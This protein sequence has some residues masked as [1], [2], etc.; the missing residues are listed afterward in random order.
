MFFIK[1]KL[2]INHT[3]GF[4]YSR[5]IVRWSRASLRQTFALCCWPSSSRA[6]C[7]ELPERAWRPSP[8]PLL[9]KPKAVPGECVDTFQPP[10]LCYDASKWLQA[11][12]PLHTLA[13]AFKIKKKKKKKSSCN[14]SWQA[15]L[16]GT[17]QMPCLHTVL[18]DV[19]SLNIASLASPF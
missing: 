13:Q 19:V 10:A 1:K 8:T 9:G 5:K 7:S 16:E 17:W 2:I 14:K 4:T 11:R 15:L 12:Y 3:G 6:G 18:G